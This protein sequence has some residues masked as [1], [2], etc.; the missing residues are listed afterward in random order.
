M[1]ALDAPARTLQDHPAFSRLP[2]RLLRAFELRELAI[3]LAADPEVWRSVVRH[4]PHE[5]WHARLH[6]APHFEAYLLGWHGDQDTRL[7]D[8]GGSA[9]AFCVTEG[10]L[11]EQHGRIGRS[12]LRDRRHV[13]GTAVS[14][15]PTYLHNLGH[16]DVGTATSVHVYSPPLQVMRFYEPQE[17]G[18]LQPVYQLPVAGP[19]PDDEADPIFLTSQGLVRS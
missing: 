10:T 8:H 5:R 3:E 2:D 18:S 11:S 9:G 14:F 13:A 17:D 4:D 1:S 12:T 15:S 7:H 16:H 19:E 6:W